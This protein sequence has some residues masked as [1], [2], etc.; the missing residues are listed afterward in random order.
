[1]SNLKLTILFPENNK[2]TEI[3]EK[4]GTFYS[5]LG[6]K[7]KAIKFFNKIVERINDPKIIESINKKIKTIKESL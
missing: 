6:N 3:Y 7:K 4:I 2:L 1:D 5:K